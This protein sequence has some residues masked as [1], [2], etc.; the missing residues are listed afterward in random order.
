V[1]ALLE[2][3]A[4]CKH[5]LDVRMQELDKILIGIR[6]TGGYKYRDKLTN[7]DQEIT[8][9]CEGAERTLR[10]MVCCAVVAETVM[11]EPDGY[12]GE[13]RMRRYAER[14]NEVLAERGLLA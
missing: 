2:P 13:N 10:R 7:T 9:F 3:K 11:M 14:L 4:L 8:A 1:E 6:A 12:S 5:A